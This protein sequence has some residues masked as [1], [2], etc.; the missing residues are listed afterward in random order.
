LY[1]SNQKA[2]ED[3]REGGRAAREEVTTNAQHAPP[4]EPQPVNLHIST[5]LGISSGFL[6]VFRIIRYIGYQWK[7]IGVLVMVDRR[8]RLALTLSPDTHSAISRIAAAQGRTM[9]SVVNDFL[10]EVQ[11][12]F[13][14]MASSLELVSQGKSPI[15]ILQKM[16]GNALSEAGSV[17]SDSAATFQKDR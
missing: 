17:L 14:D 16:M 3:E 6:Y 15:H 7:N 1:T 11:P 9:V 2:G 5:N 13:E 10:D 12:Y 8:K 4:R